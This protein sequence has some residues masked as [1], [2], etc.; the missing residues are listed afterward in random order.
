MTTTSA[1]LGTRSHIVAPS[2]EGVS[3]ALRAALRSAVTLGGRIHR[4]RFLRGPRIERAVVARVIRTDRLV[5][6][7][8]RRADAAA[9]FAL[10]SD[11]AVTQYLDWPERTK[12]QS[13]RH[14]RDRTRHTRL[15]QTNDF[16][17]LAVEYEGRLIGDVSLHLRDVAS[18]ERSAEIGWVV[19]PDVAGKGLATEAATALLDV[20]FDQLGARWVS[21]V[22]DVR[23]DRSIALARRLGFLPVGHLKGD[24]VMKLA[25][26]TVEVSEPEVTPPVHESRAALRRAA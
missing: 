16:L 21:A 15:L 10:Q 26:P 2:S 19:S 9:W 14:L 23:N 12:A 4:P 7:P 1:R 20:A 22:M 5:L 25:A 6:R 3:D 11:R 13:R 18:D 24:L 8:H 17:A